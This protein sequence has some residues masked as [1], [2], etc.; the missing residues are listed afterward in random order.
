MLAT[1]LM[2]LAAL[3]LVGLS[4]AGLR[5]PTK[6]VLSVSAGNA[7]FTADAGEC[8]GVGG[9]LQAQTPKPN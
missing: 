3:V 2:L 4:K 6:L 9:S 7:S 8:T 5:S 1:Q